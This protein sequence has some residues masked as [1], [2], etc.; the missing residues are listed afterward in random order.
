MVI[1]RFTKLAL[2]SNNTSASE[3]KLSPFDS[4]DVPEP[5]FHGS[6]GNRIINFQ[7]LMGIISILCC[8][9][10]YATGLKLAEDS[11]E[12][13]FSN[14]CVACSCGFMTGFTSTPKENKK[15][16]LNTLLVF[17]LILTGRGFTADKKLLCIL[18]LPCIS[19]NT[20]RAHELK[21]LKVVQLCSEENMKAA[22]KE[23]Q[24]FKK[25]YN[26]CCFGRWHMAAERRYVT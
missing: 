17:G 22:S 3:A 23:V 14:L 25:K 19:K 1:E 4:F 7:A 12:G 11:K 8:P 26:L 2:N 21:L 9:E 16:S 10:C 6:T 13:L 18:Y 20:F 5:E 24:T 15:F